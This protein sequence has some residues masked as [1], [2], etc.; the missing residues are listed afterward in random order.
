MYGCA[1]AAAAAKPSDGKNQNIFLFF[2]PRNDAVGTRLAGWQITSITS[3]FRELVISRL[4]IF[5][6]AATIALTRAFHV[7]FVTDNN[8]V[9][10][11]SREKPDAERRRKEEAGSRKRG[12]G[13]GRRNSSKFQRSGPDN[14]A[15]QA[16][17]IKDAPD[18][19]RRCERARSDGVAISSIL[20]EEIL[21]AKQKRAT[22]GIRPGIRERANERTRPDIIRRNFC[23]TGETIADAIIRAN[24]DATRRGAAR[25]QKSRR[26]LHF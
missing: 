13:R 8:P 1:A 23:P 16:S 25:R 6:T 26:G 24:G 11:E 18:I 9:T 14:S 7:L 21:R 22:A 5:H 19:R 12:G 2:F 3:V 4:V 17:K 10:S 20:R 15:D